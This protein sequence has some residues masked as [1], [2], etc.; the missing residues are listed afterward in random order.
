MHRAILECA[1]PTRC[2]RSP[3]AAT[4]DHPAYARPTARR[5]SKGRG[6]AAH[7]RLRGADY[8]TPNGANHPRVRGA[9]DTGVHSDQVPYDSSSRVWGRPVRTVVRPRRR[10]IIP[11]ARG[12][13]ARAARRE[14]AWRDHPRLREVDRTG[15]TGGLGLS[16]CMRGA[17][18][19]GTQ[20]AAKPKGPPP[21]ARGRQIATG[22][23]H[24]VAWVIPACAGPTGGAGAPTGPMP[25]HPSV[26][27]ADQRTRHTFVRHPGPSPRA[28][29]RRPEP[30]PRGSDRRTIP[31]CAGPTP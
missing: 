13:P 1:E 21:H 31:A 23:P 24:L 15:G 14:C 25:N 22:Q 16:P 8:E 20:M 12:R 9:D 4:Q 5:P 2:T 27:G 19:A 6:V 17:D 28:R 26:R 18:D 11:P 3:M 7:P 29:G 10:G 30:D